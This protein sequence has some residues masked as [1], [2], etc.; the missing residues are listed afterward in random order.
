MGI[1]E[2]LLVD[3]DNS[4]KNYVPREWIDASLPHKTSGLHAHRSPRLTPTVAVIVF[5]RCSSDATEAG[6]TP[7]RAN[8]QHI[9]RGCVHVCVVESLT[10]TTQAADTQL[11]H[12]ALQ[13]LSLSHYNNKKQFA[14]CSMERP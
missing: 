12:A 4:C 1:S 13:L 10:A 6:S 3:F 14:R 9:D 7:N 5:K 11:M 8:V 2:V